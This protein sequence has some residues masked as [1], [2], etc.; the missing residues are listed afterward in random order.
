MELI[1]RKR[2]PLIAYRENTNAV[3]WCHSKIGMQASGSVKG[4]RNRMK[5]QTPVA[6]LKVQNVEEEIIPATF[7]TLAASA[8]SRQ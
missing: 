4:L 6:K 8:N 1:L 5:F 7:T 3:E 2:M